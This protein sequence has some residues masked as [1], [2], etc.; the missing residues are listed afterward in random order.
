MP[1]EEPAAPPAR[2]EAWPREVEETPRVGES[3]A[4]RA[5]L[6]PESEPALELA[7][8][9]APAER[10]SRPALRASAWAL[11]ERPAVPRAQV[12]LRSLQVEAPVRELVAPSGPV[13]RPVR[14]AASESRRAV[15]RLE[16]VRPE[17]RALV[18]AA[19]PAS[20]RAPAVRE[21]L[22]QRR[23]VQAEP[24]GR[25]V[26]APPVQRALTAPP[27]RHRHSMAAPRVPAR[28]RRVPRRPSVRP[29]ECSSA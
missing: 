22:R 21:S 29:P 1:V 15:A 16:L 17:E 26:P 8:G 7:V 6:R 11:A 9:V 25:W 18:A 23:A 20:E 28:Q 27:A 4:E 14:V 5:L 13:S 3:A 2:A 12:V 19:P 10:E 24:A